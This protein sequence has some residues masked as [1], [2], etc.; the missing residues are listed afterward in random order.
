MLQLIEFTPVLA[1][2]IA[3]AMNG[4]VI[5]IGN[6][7]YQFDGIY[8]ATAVLMGS[9]VALLAVIGLWKRKVE[10]RLLWIVAITLT[11]GS[12]T[13]FFHNPRFIQWKFTVIYW[14]F[15][16]VVLGSHLLT[17]K[18]ILQRFLGPQL[19]IPGHVAGRLSW[20]WGCYFLVVGTLNLIV[21]Y[22][23]PESTW[24]SYK[25]WSSIGYTLLI[26]VITALVLAPH[27]QMTDATN[28]D[29]AQN[30]QPSPTG[31]PGSP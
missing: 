28:T 1:F 29:P 22:H 19:S 6:F 27:L 15:S 10:K 7:H 18:S 2:F 16:S 3:Y 24:V 25:L 23:F 14:I 11:M 26:S 5:D 8:S 30:N 31:K 9:S 21:A 20:I 12:A 4:H 13:L 17:D